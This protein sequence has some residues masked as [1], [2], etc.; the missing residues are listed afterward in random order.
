MDAKDLR[1]LVRFDENGPRHEPLYET[2]RLWSELVCLDRN[3]AL[4]PISDA[5][6]D[7][8][9][10]VITG[11]VVVQVDRSRKRREQWETALVPAGSE[12]SISNASGDPA[13]VL[14]VASPP[15]RRS[16]AT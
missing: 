11:K 3:D 16:T 14:I 1:D 13:V 12:L 8:L 6:S 7:A 15:P 4:G 10:L 2:E 9:V 5:E